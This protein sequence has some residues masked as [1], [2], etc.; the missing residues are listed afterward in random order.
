MQPSRGQQLCPSDTLSVSLFGL[1]RCTKQPAARVGTMVP[2]PE[3]T[4]DPPGGPSPDCFR[5]AADSLSAPRGRQPRDPWVSAP[6]STQRPPQACTHPDLGVLEEQSEPLPEFRL[7]SQAPPAAPR[8][9][10]LWAGHCHPRK[11]GRRLWWQPRPCAAA[12]GTVF[13]PHSEQS[14]RTCC[15]PGGVSVLKGRWRRCPA[16]RP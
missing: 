7:P 2:P 10:P 15:A 16:V 8:L 4:E 14:L 5:S 1:G 13:T 9:S 11:P 3:T 6:E 12:A